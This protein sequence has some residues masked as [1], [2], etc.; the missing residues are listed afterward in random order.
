[1]SVSAVRAFKE[2]ILSHGNAEDPAILFRNFMGREPELDALLAR[3]GLLE[4]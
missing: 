3:D 2:K 1:M 4:T